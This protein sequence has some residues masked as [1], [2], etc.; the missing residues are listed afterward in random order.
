MFNEKFCNSNRFLSRRSDYLICD[1]QNFTKQNLTLNLDS[2][3]AASF[4]AFIK[5]QIADVANS[6][7]LFESSNDTC[8]YKAA[9]SIFTLHYKNNIKTRLEQIR[10]ELVN[11]DVKLFYG[12]FFGVQN[13][14]ELSNVLLNTQSSML[15]GAYQMVM[16][17][18]DTQVLG[19]L[20]RQSKFCDP[21][22]LNLIYKLHF[23]SL[24]E[25]L[26]FTRE[27]GGPLCLLDQNEKILPKTFFM[28][29][30]K[31]Y[32]EKYKSYVITLDINV[33]I[34]TVLS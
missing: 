23:T 17:S 21:S 16:P 27:L 29:V 3:S 15:G 4:Y 5:E 28:Q 14:Q 6:I 26:N 33:F 2:P 1:F 20:L 11:K 24:K 8:N 13:L 12:A 7:I 32:I 25:L 34:A 31:E 18:I 30:Q 19:M 10:L 9:E 22:V